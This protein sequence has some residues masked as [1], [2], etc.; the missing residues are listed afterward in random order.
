MP[1]SNPYSPS[2]AIEACATEHLNLSIQCHRSWRT[3][4]RPPHPLPKKLTGMNNPT[5]PIQCHRSPR[6]SATQPR[7]PAIDANATQHRNNIDIIVIINTTI[8][9][10]NVT[11]TGE[12]RNPRRNT[13]QQLVSLSNQC[14]YMTGINNNSNISITSITTTTTILLLRLSPSC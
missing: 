6:T 13:S 14:L 9:L 7:Q 8:I 4:T 1:P 11:P 12:R 5:F 2:N 10:T 3:P